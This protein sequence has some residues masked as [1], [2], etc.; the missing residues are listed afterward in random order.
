MNFTVLQC[1]FI[2]NYAYT[3]SGC[4]YFLIILQT[5]IINRGETS[6]I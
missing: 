2:E 6:I 1:N 5:F 4:I 3:F